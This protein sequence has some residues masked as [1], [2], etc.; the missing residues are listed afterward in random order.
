M[1]FD[2]FEITNRASARSDDAASYDAFSNAASYFAFL[3]ACWRRN[4]QRVGF[5]VGEW[6]LSRPY[7]AL[8]LASCS[9]RD[10]AGSF[11]LSDDLHDEFEMLERTVESLT[12][13]QSVIHMGL[14]WHVLFLY[15]RVYWKRKW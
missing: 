1:L 9:A 8:A 12:G 5:C 11:K 15:S 7:L 14:F 6:A 3:E 10:S 2:I 13:A 4:R